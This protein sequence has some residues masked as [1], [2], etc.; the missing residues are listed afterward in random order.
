[1]SSN[2]KI[3]YLFCFLFFEERIERKRKERKRKK[4]EEEGRK[5]KGKKG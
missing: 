4:K 3:P 2:S 1:M 5:G